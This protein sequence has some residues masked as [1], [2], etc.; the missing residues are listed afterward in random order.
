MPLPLISQRFPDISIM[1]LIMQVD[2]L[3]H[4]P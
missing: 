4:L 2:H 3:D 1:D